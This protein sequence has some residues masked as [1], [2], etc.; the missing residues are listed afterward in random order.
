MFPVLDTNLWRQPN[1]A[2]LCRFKQ[3]K[4]GNNLWPSVQQPLPGYSPDNL[5]TQQ[6]KIKR[7]KQHGHLTKVLLRALKW[8]I[9]ISEVAFWVFSK[10]YIPIIIKLSLSYA[11]THKF[12]VLQLI[13]IQSKYCP[14]NPICPKTKTKNK[15]F[16]AVFIVL[17]TFT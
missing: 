5:V 9:I 11:L 10:L 2:I 15:T 13:W 14:D 4:N 1:L 16:I 12:R 8:I 3:H 7:I 17:V 6:K